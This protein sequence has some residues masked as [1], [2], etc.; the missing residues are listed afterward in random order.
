MIAPLHTQ[1]TSSERCVNINANPL[2]RDTSDIP[3]R[4]FGISVIQHLIT[5]L[6]I[7]VPVSFSFLVLY[8]DITL[9]NYTFHPLVGFTLF[10]HFAFLISS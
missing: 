10:S 3:R 7:N 4:D 5:I 8:S 6:V 2:F 1:I 9:D